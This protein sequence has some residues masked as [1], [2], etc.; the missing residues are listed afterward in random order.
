VIFLVSRDTFEFS[1]GST[2]QLTFKE[3]RKKMK[4]LALAVLLILTTWSLVWG[5]A[6]N[7]PN[8][9]TG[10]PGENLCSGCH[11]SYTENSGSGILSTSGLPAS[12]DPLA[13]YPVTVTLSESG[14]SSWGFEVV[15]K[16]SN[17]LQAGTLTITDATNTISGVSS[18]ITYIKQT[19]AGTYAGTVNGP[20]S[21]GFN[22]TAPAAGTGKVYFYASGVAADDNGSSSGDYC[23]HISQEVPE[24]ATGVSDN[25][26]GGGSA[27]ADRFELRQNYPNPFNL[28][29]SINYTL[30]ADGLVNL[31]IYNILGQKVGTLINQKEPAGS[32]SVQWDSKDEKGRVVPGGIYFYIL[33]AGGFTSSKKMVLLK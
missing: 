31:T 7:P 14:Q 29:T 8:R 3:R 19:S 5:Y 30:K 27:R 22:W 28:A 18:G 25:Q 11:N 32:Y 17:S 13:T 23:Y 10:A 20:V 16:D 15:V 4:R 2:L 33:K 1:G 26:S 21:W 9:R 6:N 12:Y 24:K